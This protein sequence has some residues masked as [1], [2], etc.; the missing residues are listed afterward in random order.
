MY[1]DASQ[2][3]IGG[4]LT[5]INPENELEIPLGVYSY[6]LKLTH[7][8]RS[9]FERELFAAYNAIKYFA[10]YVYARNF[11]LYSD[12]S[13]L[14]KAIMG[15]IHNPLYSV[16]TQTQLRF[17]K[18]KIGTVK[19]ITGVANEV[20][21]LLS[22][23]N[24]N[25]KIDDIQLAGN[26]NKPY[27]G[28]KNVSGKET[29]VF[30]EN[31]S[32]TMTWRPFI[33]LCT[34]MDAFN[35]TKDKKRNDNKI[36]NVSMA[37]I[38][39]DN[40]VQGDSGDEMD[41]NKCEVNEV[42]VI[43]TLNN[44]EENALAPL[45]ME[46]D[47]EKTPFEKNYDHELNNQIEPYVFEPHQAWLKIKQTHAPLIHLNTIACE[48]VTEQNNTLHDVNERSDTP[49]IECYDGQL[50]NAC[51]T[52][53]KKD[54][55]FI[56]KIV[57][58]TKD[59]GLSCNDNNNSVNN[60]EKN[61]ERLRSNNNGEQRAE[62]TFDDLQR[63]HISLA[64]KTHHK[65]VLIKNKNLKCIHEICDE[66]NTA[67]NECDNK[68]QMETGGAAKKRKYK[69]RI[70]DNSQQLN[71]SE[72]L[73]LL[74]K[75]IKTN[76]EII[77]AT[78]QRMYNNR[79]NEN[80]QSLWEEINGDQNDDINT[81]E[82]FL[83]EIRDDGMLIRTPLK[84]N[85]AL[86][87]DT[88]TASEICFAQNNDPE[89]KA[90]LNSQA[91]HTGNRQHYVYEKCITDGKKKYCIYVSKNC[92]VYT[93]KPLRFRAF[94]MIHNIAHVGIIKTL[95]NIKQEFFWPTMKEDIKML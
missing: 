91:N 62:T 69:E 16:T 27:T 81:T 60:S 75:R 11:T 18:E 48:N 24:P 45:E 22:R 2:Y 68:K 83:I 55:N 79:Q 34:E 46:N 12:N 38:C 92:K 8:K 54:W 1:T 9:A 66:S 77:N 89:L 3:A 53:N 86:G 93:P 58:E 49:I 41:K 88:I 19:Q 33:Y 31:N 70:S 85:Y 52:H 80:A 36:K 90:L 30:D 17:I 78:Y 50:M 95:K 73:S 14:V 61:D 32:D 7:Q 94:K 23:I 15:N 51:I 28:M 25:I 42:Y 5:Q 43:N 72:Q 35:N 56:E 21:D 13:S 40:A 59:N 87:G 26:V 4:Y 20:A 10:P 64:E 37:L 29:D 84:P 65:S 44:S 82:C 67:L 76:N 57:N 63:K 47:I 39:D 6:G 71:T 74:T